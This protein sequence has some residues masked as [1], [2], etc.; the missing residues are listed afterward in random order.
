MSL[1]EAISDLVQRRP[2]LIASD[3]D[4]T[5]A[6]IVAHPDEAMADPRALDSLRKLAARPGVGVAIVSGRPR[7]DLIGFVG[8][9]GEFE[10]IGEHGNDYG[11]VADISEIAELV[12]FFEGVASDLPGARVEVKQHSVGFHYRNVPEDDRAGA[13]ARIR[14]W[15]ECKPGLSVTEGKMIV[16]ASVTD[17]NKGDAISDLV[18][19]DAYAGVLFV[20][21]DTT[22]ETVFAVLGPGDVGVKV[23]PGETAAQYRIDDVEAVVDL[24]EKVGSLIDDVR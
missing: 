21:D 24:F 5:L 10:L 18:R 14:S 7:E 16:E 20:G 11:E 2:L 19:D 12:E 3:F 13:L 8:G 6:P 22:D 4:G 15:L 17:R 1:E 23:G 9:V